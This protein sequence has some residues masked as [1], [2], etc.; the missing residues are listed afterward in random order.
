MGITSFPLLMRDYPKYW[1]Y[2][3][4]SFLFAYFAKEYKFPNKK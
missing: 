1:W 3:L 2:A 4:L